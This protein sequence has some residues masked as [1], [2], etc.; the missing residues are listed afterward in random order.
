MLIYACA[1]PTSG[2]P[3]PDACSAIPGQITFAANH[4]CGLR[5]GIRLG[6][7]MTEGPRHSRLRR[8]RMN[9][10]SALGR[11]RFW[12]NTFLKDPAFEFRRAA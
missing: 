12:P 2:L 4:V 7:S 11:D 9:L 1:I 3:F 8:L 6:F 5:G 10:Q